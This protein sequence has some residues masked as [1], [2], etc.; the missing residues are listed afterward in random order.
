[1]GWNTSALFLR[2]RSVKAVLSFLPDIFDYEPMREGVWGDEAMVGRAEDLYLASDATWCQMWDPHTRFA[3]KVDVLMEYEANHTPILRGTRAL[4]A[5][6]ASVTSTYGFWLYDDGKLVRQAMYTSGEPVNIIGEPLP[7]E[8]Q[9]EI[10]SWGHDEIY[11]WAVI[12]ALTG[13]T[14][15]F[16]SDSQGFAA[17]N[18]LYAGSTKRAE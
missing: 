2:D 11:V 18:V 10:P 16:V 14:S 13:Y 1:M 8:S 12:E 4:S 6:F 15:D 7:V 5:L 9:V 3:P 17:Y